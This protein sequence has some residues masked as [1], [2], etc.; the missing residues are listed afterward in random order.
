MGTSDTGLIEKTYTLFTM[1]IL[2]NLLMTL[3][4]EVRY[5]AIL[6]VTQ[7]GGSFSLMHGDTPHLK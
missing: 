4:A 1:Q 3:Y 2:R 5:G 7:I 6:Q